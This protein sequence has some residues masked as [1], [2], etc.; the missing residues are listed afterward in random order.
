MG[1]LFAALGREAEVPSLLPCDKITMYGILGLNSSIIKR[2]LSMAQWVE[3]SIM[4]C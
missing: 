3:P 2:I 4:Y 1:P